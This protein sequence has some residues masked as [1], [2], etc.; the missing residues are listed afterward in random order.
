L[1]TEKELQ[2]SLKRKVFK[3]RATQKLSKLNVSPPLAKWNDCCDE[4]T[5]GSALS[6]LKEAHRRKVK[7]TMPKVTGERYTKNRND[8]KVTHKILTEEYLEK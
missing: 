4:N 2:A 6:K 5:L 1:Q 3:R 7:G 8:F